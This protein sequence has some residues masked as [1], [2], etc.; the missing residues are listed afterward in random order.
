MTVCFLLLVMLGVSLSLHAIDFPVAKVPVKKN[1]NPIGYIEYSFSEGQYISRE[2][3][4]QEI[5]VSLYNNT[6]ERVSVTLILKGSSTSKSVSLNPYQKRDDVSFWTEK[7]FNGIVIT[8][9]YVE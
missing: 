9:V 4:G 2:G 3:W 6:N 5:K 7:K 8:N 1:G